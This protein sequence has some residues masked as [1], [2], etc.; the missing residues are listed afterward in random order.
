MQAPAL[1]AIVPYEHDQGG[2]PM[3]FNIRSRAGWN[4]LWLALSVPWWLFVTWLVWGQY[5]TEEVSPVRIPYAS[6]LAERQE[7]FLIQLASA[8]ALPFLIYGCVYAL[9]LVTRWILQGFRR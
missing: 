5:P 9:V 3:A 2:H 7:Q 4:R 8:V 1:G 6:S